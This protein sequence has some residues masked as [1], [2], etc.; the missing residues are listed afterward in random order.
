MVEADQCVV[1]DGLTAGEAAMAEP[2]AVA[3]HAM[4]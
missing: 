1:V 3:L 4:K 2:L